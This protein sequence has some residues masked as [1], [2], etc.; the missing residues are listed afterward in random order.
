MI[1]SLVSFDVVWCDFYIFWFYRLGVISLW[2]IWTDI[3]EFRL[4]LNCALFGVIWCLLVWFS[5]IFTYFSVNR[6]FI[7][8]FECDLVLNYLMWYYLGHVWSVF[9]CF[10]V[11]WCLIVWLCVIFTFLVLTE[12]LWCGYGVIWFWMSWCDIIDDRLGRSSFIFSVICY[13]LVCFGV[14][15]IYF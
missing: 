1:C 7:V 8:W 3:F 2:M 5:V 12:V 14:I 13:L 6:C 11:V 10:G 4:G 9:G 15:C